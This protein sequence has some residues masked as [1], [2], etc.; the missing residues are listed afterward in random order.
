MNNLNNPELN[1]LAIIAVTLI[2]VVAMTLI[3]FA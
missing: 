1:A 2:A 3:S